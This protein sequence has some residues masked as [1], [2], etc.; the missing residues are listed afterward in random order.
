[1]ARYLLS[2]MDD[3][4]RAGLQRGREWIGPEGDGS[5]GSLS[6]PFVREAAERIAGGHPFRELRDGPTAAETARA[7]CY[8]A[9]FHAGLSG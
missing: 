7:E 6:G 2:S 3:M 8:M 1:M 5:L 4:Y 9:G